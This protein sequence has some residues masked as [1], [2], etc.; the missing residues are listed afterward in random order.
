[1]AILCPSL[2]KSS[3]G[4][5]ADLSGRPVQKNRKPGSVQSTP[6]NQL[7]NCVAPRGNLSIFQN[8]IKISK[9]DETEGR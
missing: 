5:L 7:S 8:A 4:Y 9:Q 1:M 2:S 6:G 3:A